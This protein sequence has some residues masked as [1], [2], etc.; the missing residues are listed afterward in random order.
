MD[1]AS[2]LPYGMQAGRA[3]KIWN[4]QLRFK[5]KVKNN[6]AL[7]SLYLFLIGK[8]KKDC[9]SWN[10]FGRQCRGPNS[11]VP[12]RGY[13]GF[14]SAFS[15]LTRLFQLLGKR[16]RLMRSSSVAATS[17]SE[18]L[19][20]ASHIPRTAFQ[21]IHWD[22]AI[23]LLTTLPRHFAPQTLLSE[24]VQNPTRFTV[25][26]SEISN[27]LH[28]HQDRA[29]GDLAQVSTFIADSTTE[30]AEALETQL[31]V[32]V[33]CAKP[34]DSVSSARRHRSGAECC[35]RACCWLCFLFVM[36]ITCQPEISL[37]IHIEFL[38]IEK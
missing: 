16:P 24:C 4:K 19:T 15:S 26:G 1:C 5:I 28:S 29:S 21:T 27:I 20:S 10:I 32:T 31:W 25:R 36:M 3:E 12:R 30:Q 9:F 6:I 7:I 17:T 37:N 18:W 38:K 8:K 13:S 33:G 34:K 22:I 23:S 2:T 14:L 35:T 11:P